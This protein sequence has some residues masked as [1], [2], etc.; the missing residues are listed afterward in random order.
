MI[1]DIV[2]FTAVGVFFLSIIVLRILWNQ[3]LLSTRAFGWIITPIMLIAFGA[4]IH[5]QYFSSNI[6]SPKT[7]SASGATPTSNTHI[8]P[9][10]FGFSLVSVQAS[11]DING[12]YEYPY[13]QFQVKNIT[14]SPLDQPYF[15]VIFEDPSQHIQEG[16]TNVLMDTLQPGYTSETQKMESDTGLS[17]QTLPNLVA[18]IQY[19]DGS[20]N[21]DK[22]IETIPVTI[23][24]QANDLAN[25]VNAIGNTAG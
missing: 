17:I 21:G 12:N 8:Q 6:S 4:V 13:V 15:K 24:Q 2:A 16:S 23:P 18:V 1:G 20:G 14:N 5:Q 10:S 19:D 11:W 7:S 3:K 9:L 22:T 25:L